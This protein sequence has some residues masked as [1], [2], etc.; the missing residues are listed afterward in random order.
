MKI[1]VALGGNA[2]IKSNQKGTAKEQGKNLE[3]ACN[4][5]SKLIK[6]G[7]KLIITHG[8][9]PQVGDILLQNECAKKKV[10]SMPLD[11]CGAESQGLIG[12]LIQQAITKK[13]KQEPVTLITR[14]RVD[15]KDRAFKNP[16]KP[17][18]PFY[19][20]KRKEWKM[21]E[22]KGKGWRRVVPSPDPK[23]IIEDKVITQLMKSNEIVI[24]GGG[25]GIPVIK[26]GKELVGVEAVID[27]D[28]TAERIAALVK[29]DILLILTDISQ[30]CI[31]Y[32]KKSQKGLRK[33]TLKEAKY[34]LKQGQFP[35][36]S[37]GPKIL[38]A[39][40]FL[41]NGGKKVMIANLKDAEMAMEG[42][43]GTT[44]VK[45]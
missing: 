34:Y 16:T 31:N 39:I 30:V 36:G 43:A 11:V 2:L 27:K 38:S 14:V 42:K 21:V 45:G 7:H 5:I 10:P 17:V 22:Q 15:A 3:I 13:I 1:V 20:S 33:I 9:G 44:I 41:E 12:Y 37:M 19:K 23:E 4:S 40:R 24:C 18:G 8:N 28:L 6:K 32:R 29:A 26:R 25:G 35:D